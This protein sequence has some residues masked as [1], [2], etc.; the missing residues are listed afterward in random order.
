MT[1]VHDID[2][3]GSRRLAA[4]SSLA[5]DLEQLRRAHAVAERVRE[6]TQRQGSTTLALP[7]G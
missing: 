6:Q 1:N 2:V 7:R 4:G 5:P 3:P